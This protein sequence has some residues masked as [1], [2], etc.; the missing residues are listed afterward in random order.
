MSSS[1]PHRCT[2]FVATHLLFSAVILASV[3]AARAD[4][5]IPITY[6][7]V[8]YPVDQSD[9]ENPG[10]DLLSGTIITDGNLGTLTGSDIVGGTLTIVSPAGTFQEL[11]LQ[12]LGSH[13]LSGLK[14]TADQLLI[15]HNAWLGLNYTSPN[16][17]LNVIWENDSGGYYQGSVRED[18][19]L[20]A[21]PGGELFW[22]LA[23]PPRAIG[24]V[25][26]RTCW[27]NVRVGKAA[28]LQIGASGRTQASVWRRTTAA[29]SESP[30]SSL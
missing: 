16:A 11:T 23:S 3:S 9:C 21:I 1:R 10:T 26:R 4:N 24:A 30:R 17:A 2:A 13:D 27:Q 22:T 25:S 15:P 18:G 8:N 19:N 14:A 6:N 20:P 29:R 5:I 28:N 12:S 7:I